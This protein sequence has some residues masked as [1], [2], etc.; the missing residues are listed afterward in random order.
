MTD[1]FEQAKDLFL[2]GVGDFEAGRLQEA[3]RVFEASLELLPGRVSTL[4]NLGATKLRL[5]KPLEALDTLDQALARE[6][7]DRDAW[8]HR[9]EALA[10]L[11]RYEEAIA[12]CDKA[13]GIEAGFPPAWERR[14]ML[15]TRLRRHEEALIALDRLAAL[16]PRHGETWQHRGQ[17]LQKLGR[18]DEALLSYDKALSLDRSLAQAW[19]LRGGILKDQRRLDE[20]VEC[21]REALAHGGEAELNRYFLASLVGRD[22]PASAPQRYVRS[23][24]DDY[25]DTFDE[26]LV[27]GLRYEAHRFLIDNLR[28]VGPERFGAALDLGC[29]TG[30]CGPLVKP[31][32]QRLDGVDLSP[33]MLDKARALGVYEQ[34]VQGDLVEHLRGTPQSYDLV[35]AAD[36]FIYVGD[37]E[38]VF[39][40]VSR[41]MSRGGVF[42]F[43][44]EQAGDEQTFQLTMQQRYAHSERY[45][46]QLAE[47]HGFE[48][49]K[50]LRHAIREDQRAPIAGLYF[51][52][53]KA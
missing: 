47:R 4:V 29:G 22:A 17:T 15:L 42:C 38:P 20:A 33:L 27:G 36:V 34:L 23:L 30:L 28:G 1:P 19:T 10:R 49:V 37:L 13:I 39:A 48:T 43:S 52:L 50:M 8:C 40:G 9:S 46:R 16:L 51:Y 11:G 18:H 45:V 31:A 7:G 2:Q 14:A 26:H 12:S 24:F 35:L 3:E 21:F 53:F 6:P 25:A 32:V 44:A 5:S 41:V